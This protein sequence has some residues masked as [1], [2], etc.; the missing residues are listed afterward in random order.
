[1]TDQQHP[2]TPPA[3]LVQ[4]W[5]G[6]Y[7]GT[8]VTG[9]V[10]TVELAL[11]VQAAQWGWDQRGAA[12]EAELQQ[13]AD[14]ELEACL[15]WISNQDWTWTKAQLLD[16]R[17]PKPLSK[18]EQA[19]KEFKEVE[20]FVLGQLEGCSDFNKFKTYVNN[21]NFTLEQLND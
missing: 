8:T 19:L 7:F 1:M 15:E 18:K 11:A 10:S 12:N 16:A 2:I 21:I 4:Q 9:E 17:R 6:T 20:D 5:L 14:Q 3:H 13:R